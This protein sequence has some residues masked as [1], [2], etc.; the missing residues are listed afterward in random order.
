[1]TIWF[2]INMNFKSGN[3][4]LIYQLAFVYFYIKF[5]IVDHLLISLQNDLIY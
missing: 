4:F 3:I 5:V 2:T 1:M